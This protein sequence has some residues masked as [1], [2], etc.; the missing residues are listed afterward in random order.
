VTSSVSGNDVYCSC[1]RIF[2]LNCCALSA[3]VRW[4]PSLL[5]AIVT[6]LVTQAAFFSGILPGATPNHNQAARRQPS[7]PEPA[8][9]RRNTPVIQPRGIELVAVIAW[10]LTLRRA[11][12]EFISHRLPAKAP[13]DASR[14]KGKTG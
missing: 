8:W 12:H 1:F 13:H 3:L 9:H 5:A 10:L 6:Q 14:R 2:T 4:R 7:R 11:D